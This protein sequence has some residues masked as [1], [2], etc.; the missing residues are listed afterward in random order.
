MRATARGAQ[1]LLQVKGH[2]VGP[3]RSCELCP[4]F[5][6]RANILVGN[7]SLAP[8]FYPRQNI[9]DIISGYEQEVL[10]QYMSLF[11]L[12]W[13]LDQY[14][15]CSSELIKFFDIRSLEAVHLAHLENLVFLFSTIRNKQYV[16]WS[17]ESNVIASKP[18]YV[19][20]KYAKQNTCYTILAKGQNK[21]FLLFR[22]KK[23]RFAFS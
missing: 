18:S 4:S 6:L 15:L 2:N 12:F 13:E 5:Y 9:P 7:I 1:S 22:E 3:F 16:V 20:F 10:F 14:D 19:F 11:V 21:C 17:W 8:L 23:C